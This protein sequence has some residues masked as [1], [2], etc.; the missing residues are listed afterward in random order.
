M[1]RFFILGLVLISCCAQ[2]YAVCECTTDEIMTKLKRASNF[3]KTSFIRDFFWTTSTAQSTAAKE[4][5]ETR[6]FE[7]AVQNYI[8]RRCTVANN[9]IECR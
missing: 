5:V 3:E 9:K 2:V 4:V 1:K 6:E 7:E 8:E